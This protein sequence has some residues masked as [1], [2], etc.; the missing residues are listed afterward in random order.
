MLLKTVYEIT[1]AVKVTNNGETRR[2]DY[3]LK[4]QN[5]PQIVIHP[6]KAIVD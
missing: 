1:V 6:K 2:E 3:H 5:D 4:T